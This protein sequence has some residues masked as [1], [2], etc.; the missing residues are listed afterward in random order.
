MPNHQPWILRTK[1]RVAAIM[2]ASS[3][4]RIIA[5][6]ELACHLFVSGATTR[7]QNHMKSGKPKN[8]YGQHSY[9]SHQHNSESIVRKKKNVNRIENLSNVR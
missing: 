4:K 1:L 9:H 3:R 2:P 5:T 8:W 7:H 6:L